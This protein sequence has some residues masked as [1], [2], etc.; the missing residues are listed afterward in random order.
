MFYF[1]HFT[2]SICCIFYLQFLRF[3]S[4]LWLILSIRV[5]I[6]IHYSITFFVGICVESTWI[7]INEIYV[8]IR[9]L[10]GSNL[11]YYNA[12]RLQLWLF[13]FVFFCFHYHHIN[14]LKLNQ[15]TERLRASGGSS[16]SER[17][18]D[19]NPFT[20][21]SHGNPAFTPQK[22]GKSSNIVS[23]RNEEMIIPI[24]ES[25][26]TRCVHLFLFTENN[27]TSIRI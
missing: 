21:N 15:F 9:G 14:T 13:F 24:R 18:K 22:A 8:F 10:I 4:G 17:N 2:I 1:I 23:K 20:H 11:C 19:S 16:Q 12:L 3:S 25:M 6:V 26:H 27:F 7:G 5:W